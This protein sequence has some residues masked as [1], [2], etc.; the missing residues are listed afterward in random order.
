MNLRKFT[1]LAVTLL[2]VAAPATPAFAVS[3]EIIQL[4]TQ[5]Q[6]LADRMAKMQQ[7]FDERMGVMQSLVE[8]RSMLAGAE[9]PH[10][11][12]SVAAE[13]G[14][15]RGHLHNFRTRTHHTR[16]EHIHVHA[17]T[18]RGRG[19]RYRNRRVDFALT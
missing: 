11:L 3:K 14:D 15:H 16:N 10:V 2:M 4:Q 13:P 8:Q 19:P 17:L 9:N 12:A 18:D 6:D 5:V 7:S 1:A